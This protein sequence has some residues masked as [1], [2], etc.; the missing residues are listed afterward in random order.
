[1]KILI[2]T[3]SAL[4]AMAMLV[5]CE[6]QAPPKDMEAKY[7]AL[8]EDT[9][10]DKLM[11]DRKELKATAPSM[12]YTTDLT[13]GVLNFSTTGGVTITGKFASGTLTTPVIIAPPPPVNPAGIPAGAISS[14]ILD[15]NAV[16]NGSKAWPWKFNHDAGTP[17]TTTDAVMTYPFAGAGSSTTAFNAKATQTGLAGEIWHLSFASNDFASTHFVYDAY[18]SIDDPTQVANVEMDMN[19][20]LANGLT[21]ILATQCSKYSG[22]WEWTTTTGGTHWN[23]GNIPCDPSKWTPKQF[24]HI[25]IA[26]E[27]D[28]SGVVTYDWVNMD[29]VLSNFVNAKGLSAEQLNWAKVELL[30]FQLDGLQKTGTMS[31]V[32][33]QLQIWKW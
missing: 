24:H 20:V 15:S 7:H 30:N 10:R 22:T 27:R 26:T 5:G 16:V 11:L 4:V 21:V 14:G 6:Q 19:Q 13:G 9:H 28:A 18:V 17:G 33:D 12:T 25:Q 1:M 23:K 29:G 31:A 32:V 2:V 8:A 3:C